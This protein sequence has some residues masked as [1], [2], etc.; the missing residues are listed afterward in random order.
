MQIYDSKGALIKVFNV[1]VQA[2]ELIRLEGLNALAD[3]MYLINIQTDKGT[4][5][6]KK[7]EKVGN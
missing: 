4:N 1:A 6:T 7:F 3:G 5:Y 2:G